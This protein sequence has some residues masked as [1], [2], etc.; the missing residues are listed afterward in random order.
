MK[1]SEFEQKCYDAYKLDWMQ[2]HGYTLRD[3]LNALINEDE[4][5]SAAG[6]YPEG[7]TRDIF[8]SLDSSFEYETGFPGGT[9][10]ACKDEFLGAEFQDKDYMEHLLSL[11]PNSKEME[12]FWRVM[13]SISREE[14][15]GV[16]V[17]TSAGVLRAYKNP[18]PEQPGICVMLQP[19][20]YEDEIDMAFV[21]VYENSEYAT[22]D[23]E[24]PVDV[25]IMAYGDATTEDYTVKEIIR[26]EDVIAGL[27]T[28]GME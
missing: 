26:R 11:M 2:S 22:S 5:A 25:A 20:G 8:E 16:E 10:W 24:R 12:D 21:S 9:I 17:N 14:K 7:D 15:P 13:Y 3:Y 27:R 23:G 28:G 4:E 1:K 6:N 18:D 19:V